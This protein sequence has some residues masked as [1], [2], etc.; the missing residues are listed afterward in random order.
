MLSINQTHQIIC[1]G[2][3]SLD[4]YSNATYLYNS[5]NFTQVASMNF[6]RRS[7]GCAR[8]GDKVFIAGGWNGK[9]K[10]NSVEYF[11]LHSLEWHLGPSLPINTTY[12]ELIEQ[13]GDLYFMGGK[14]FKSIYR[15]KTSSKKTVNELSWDQVGNLEKNKW[16]FVAL[17]WEKNVCK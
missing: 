6:A 1:G 7:H 3:E 14:E 8:V 9:V 17:P 5:K 15:L 10:L 11:S 16:L 2:S 12:A 4:T 13:N